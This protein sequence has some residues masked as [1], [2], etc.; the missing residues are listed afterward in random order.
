M[1]GFNGRRCLGVL[2]SRGTTKSHHATGL[3]ERFTRK[4]RGAADVTSM[5]ERMKRGL[6]KKLLASDKGISSCTEGECASRGGSGN[7][8][9]L[10]CYWRV[11][12]SPCTEDRLVSTPDR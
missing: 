3:N 7:S 1:Q 9:A 6:E 12:L 11:L 5:W 10:G 2:G 4:C 8:V